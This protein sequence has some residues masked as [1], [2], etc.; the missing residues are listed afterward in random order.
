MMTFT[1]KNSATADNA[2][3]AQPT[4]NDLQRAQFLKLK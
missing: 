2:R 4:E 1:T 3:T